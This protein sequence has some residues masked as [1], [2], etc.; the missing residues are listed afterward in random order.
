MWL[1][2][3]F[4][5]NAVL[6]FLVGFFLNRLAVA[7][8]KLKEGKTAISTGMISEQTF[9]YPS[10]TFCFFSDD[11]K[12]VLLTDS[13]LGVADR[14]NASDHVAEIVLPLNPEV[15]TF[16]MYDFDDE[17]GEFQLRPCVTVDSPGPVR[18]GNI[19][20]VRHSKS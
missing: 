9:T 1:L 19:H 10:V 14:P 8:S 11:D 20:D 4:A 2:R 3:W 12:T 18:V 6:L 17:A 16:Y 7:V 13:T 15:S 5:K